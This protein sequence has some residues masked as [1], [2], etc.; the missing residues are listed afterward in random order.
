M[1]GAENLLRPFLDKL[2][3]QAPRCPVVMNVTGAAASHVGEIHTN[4][5]SQVTAPVYWKRGV[6]A[7]DQEGSELYIEIGCGRVL[8]G[9]NR[10]IGV[11]GTSIN[12]EKLEDLETLNKE[13]EA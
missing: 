10:R 6:E 4:L 9:L 5:A 7:M 1:V 12:I 2:E 3:L 13:V 8:T 11:M